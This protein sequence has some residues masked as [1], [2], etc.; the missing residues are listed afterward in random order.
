MNDH[1]AK[2]VDPDNL[3]SALVRWVE[4]GEREVPPD[5][6]GQAG[7]GDSSIDESDAGQSLS[8]VAG[9]NVEEG[10]RG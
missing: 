4:E 8:S 7:S 3:F 5:D 2:P 10:V 1:V 6:D 9:L